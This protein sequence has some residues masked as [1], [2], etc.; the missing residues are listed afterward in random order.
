MHFVSQSE[1]RGRFRL[2]FCK[3][4][5]QDSGLDTGEEFVLNVKGI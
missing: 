5:T 3:E 1:A 2:N 4:I